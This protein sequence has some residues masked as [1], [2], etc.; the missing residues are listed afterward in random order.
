M[1]KDDKKIINEI[2]RLNELMGLNKKLL[3]EQAW[4]DDLLTGLIQAG[5]KQGDEITTLTAKL[6]DDALTTLEKTDVLEDIIRIAQ[7]EGNDDLLR[8]IN[9]QLIRSGGRLMNQLDDIIVNNRTLIQSGIDRGASK[10]DLQKIFVDDFNPNTG[11]DILDELIKRQL[12][13]KVGKEYDELISTADDITSTTTR[14][15]DDATETGTR[16]TSDDAA[17]TGARES[18]T[19]SDD[20]SEQIPNT[21]STELS[22]GS[23]ISDIF[24]TDNWSN[25]KLISLSDEEI[26]K[27]LD[28]QWFSKFMEKIN[29]LFKVTDDRLIKIQKIAKTIETTTNSQ[30]KSKLQKKLKDELEWLYKKSTNNF[31]YMRDYLETISNTN[32]SWRRQWNTIKS[33]SDNGWDFY[34]TFGSIAEYNS[35]FKQFWAGLTDDISSVFKITNKYS[36]NPY[37]LVTKTTPDEIK[38]AIKNNLTNVFKSGTKRG[39][40]EMTNEAYTT[41]IKK[42]GPKSAKVAYFRDLVLSVL[43]FNILLSIIPVMG[44]AFLSWAYRDSVKACLTTNDT[45]SEE[46]KSIQNTWIERFFLSWA[47]SYRGVDEIDEYKNP[48]IELLK[49]AIPFANDS[50]VDMNDEGYLLALEFASFLEPGYVVNVVNSLFEVLELISDP[51]DQDKFNEELKKEMDKLNDKLQDTTQ[52]IENT[53]EEEGIDVSQTD[54]EDSTPESSGEPGG[55]QHAIENLG[56]GTTKEGEFFIY[57]G[58]KYKWNGTDYDW[59]Y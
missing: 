21:N 32:L 11:D 15:T 43:K 29:N 3:N 31:V 16:E 22:D 5:A 25:K 4:I 54:D 14:V 57:D 39:F 34:K 36:M 20:L 2:N 59:V 27:V 7:R 9:T 50:K 42:Y 18:S 28:Q 19:V 12:R 8:V 17:E 37:K 46:C 45:N 52:K 23:K 55:L 33:G 13:T 38:N 6:S 24:N 56:S 58:D 40:P 47:F 35:G 26:T 44:G 1:K 30:L 49:S 53:L 10:S 48:L 51:E 41:L